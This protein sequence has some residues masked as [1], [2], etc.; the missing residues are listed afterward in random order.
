MPQEWLLKQTLYAKVDGKRPVGR[1]QTKWLDY[2][3]DAGW[4]HLRNCPSEVQSV[5]EMVTV[6][7]II[8][9]FA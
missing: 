1:L 6:L 4:N 9:I 7:V 3:K 8:Q 2:F 5:L